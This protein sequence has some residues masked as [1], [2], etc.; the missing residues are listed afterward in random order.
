M[1]SSWGNCLH[2]CSYAD[3]CEVC[4]C[5]VAAEDVVE[6]K[7]LLLLVLLLALGLR[8]STTSL[9]SI[10]DTP[11]QHNTNTATQQC[12]SSAAQPHIHAPPLPPLS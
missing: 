10:T 12:S 4:M 8:R 6:K 2:C 7:P 3:V 5:T 9:P 11:T 1:P